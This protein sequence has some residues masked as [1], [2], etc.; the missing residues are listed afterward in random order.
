M[1]LRSRGMTKIR[2]PAM[3]ATIGVIWAAVTTMVCLGA[4]NGFE[5]RKP[6]RQEI[7]KAI[8]RKPPF[9]S[10]RGAKTRKARARGTLSST[11]IA[12]E[13]TR[14]LSAEAHSAKA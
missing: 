4:V 7:D 2:I 1:M 5:G 11:A 6:M 9:G 8:T 14:D 12:G 10:M 3:S 13:V